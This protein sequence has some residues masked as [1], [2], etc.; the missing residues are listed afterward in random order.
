MVFISDGQRLLWIQKLCRGS[1]FRWSGDPYLLTY[2]TVKKVN[3]WEKN[4]CRQKGLDKNLVENNNLIK[5]S[6]LW[7]NLETLAGTKPAA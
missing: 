2:Q 4:G 3:L 7:L 5:I 1:I 6:W